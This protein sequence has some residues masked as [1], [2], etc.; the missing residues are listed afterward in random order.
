MRRINAGILLTV[1]LITSGCTTNRIH[2]DDHS[3]HHNDVPPTNTT[4]IHHHPQPPRPTIQQLDNEYLQFQQGGPLGQVPANCYTPSRYPAVIPGSL[5]YPTPA[6]YNPTYA[7]R[8][9]TPGY[10][11]NAQSYK[12]QVRV[13]FGL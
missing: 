9:S 6:H 1:V 4:V 11:S 12:A 5:Y 2:V 7:Y 8:H 13:Q 3:Y 10:S